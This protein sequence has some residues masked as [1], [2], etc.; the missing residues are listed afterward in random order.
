MNI[1]KLL[2]SA[3]VVPILLLS[4]CIQL[5]V[6]GVKNRESS[7]QTKNGKPHSIS[8]SI[9]AADR[10]ANRF[11]EQYFHNYLVGYMTAWNEEVY[12]RQMKFGAFTGGSTEPNAKENL[13][14]YQ[15]E[16]FEIDKVPALSELD[17]ATDPYAAAD[18]NSAL[19]SGRQ[20]GAQA[21]KQDIQRKL[22]TLEK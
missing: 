22:R 14:L 19:S 16:E 15:G 9:P 12:H 8:I 21:A 4:A 3:L 6:P 7:F 2:I 10:A 1:S 5:P 17:N 18:V 13:T 11:P 20:D